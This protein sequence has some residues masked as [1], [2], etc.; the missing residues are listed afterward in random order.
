MTF[1]TTEAVGYAASLL[2]VV[3]LAMTS[4]VRLRSISLVV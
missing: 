1:N 2:V 3:S 4:V